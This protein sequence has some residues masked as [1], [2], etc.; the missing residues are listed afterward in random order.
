MVFKGAMLEYDTFELIRG[1]S[2]VIKVTQRS[3]TAGKITILCNTTLCGFFWVIHSMEAYF[4]NIIGQH[5]V[6]EVKVITNIRT[7]ITYPCS[8][9]L[10]HFR[11]KNL[12]MSWVIISHQHHQ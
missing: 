5:E 6:L 7:I 11:N 1:Q 9:L 3:T 8:P 4:F 2:N 10:V 12:M